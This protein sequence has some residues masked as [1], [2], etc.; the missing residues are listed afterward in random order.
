[1]ADQSDPIG[2]N[3]MIQRIKKE[4]LSTRDTAQPLFKVKQV[5]LEISFTVER[6][7]AG[8]IN[9]QVVRGDVKKTWSEAQTVKVTLDPIIAIQDIGQNLT[10][11]EKIIAAKSL[12]RESSIE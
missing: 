5:E 3:E 6:D 4:L 8:G 1:M 7:A 9:F 11:E 12:Q 10:E 2:I